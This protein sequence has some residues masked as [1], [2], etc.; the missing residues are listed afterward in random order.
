MSAFFPLNYASQ[1]LAQGF[2]NCFDKA[3]SGQSG[4]HLVRYQ[5]PHTPQL[6]W[7]TGHGGT[8]LAT[9][10][11]GPS[12]LRSVSLQHLPR[13]PLP[14][15]FQRLAS[16]RGL[17]SSLDP[18]LRT[19]CTAPL[20]QAFLS[21]LEPHK[22]PESSLWFATA[23]QWEA[24]R[25]LLSVLILDKRTGARCSLCQCLGCDDTSHQASS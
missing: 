15:F 7:I 24:G 16:T 19:D 9:S 11:L 22:E 17:R 3:G 8:R 10:S 4:E 2:G 23:L 5:W 25:V 13:G 14:H 12:S 20:T 6:P 18:S 21:L 1:Y